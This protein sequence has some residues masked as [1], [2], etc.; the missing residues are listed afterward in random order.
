MSSSL[1]R[2]MYGRQRLLVWSM[3][4]PDRVRLKCN[5][6][7]KTNI[8]K[9]CFPSFN[10]CRHKSSDGLPA[11]FNPIADSQPASP[12]PFTVITFYKFK[13]FHEPEAMERHVRACLERLEARGRIYF[14]KIG[15][16]AQMCLPSSNTEEAKKVLREIFC[17]GLDLRLEPASFQVFNRLRLDRIK[18]PIRS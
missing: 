11:S 13:Q 16:N 17:E 8:G 18:R 12:G 2:L 15:V 9:L 10:S 6:H 5:R 14:N 7:P 1:S 3:I 4:E